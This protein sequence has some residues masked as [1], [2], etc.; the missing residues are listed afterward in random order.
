MEQ[1][2]NVYTLNVKHST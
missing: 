2:K 1:H